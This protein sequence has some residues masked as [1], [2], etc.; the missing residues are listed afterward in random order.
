MNRT[1]LQRK[2]LALLILFLAM[3]VLNVASIQA[4]T[5]F[6][7]T[8][9][10]EIIA[11]P[12]RGLQKYSITNNTY[13]SASNYSSIS[14]STIRSWRTGPEKVT[15]IYRYFLLG[16]FM[17]TEIS[18]TYLNNIQ[19]DFDRIRNAGLKTL[20]R[21]SYTNRQSTD[22][23][24]PVKALILR[25]I[26]QLAP[27]LESNK[28]VIVAHQA[29]FIGTWGEWY[30]TNS[31]EFGTHGSISPTQW[32]NRK[33]VV[34][35]M[36]AGTPVEIPLQ[37]RYPQA[38]ITMYGSTPLTGETAY[39]DSPQAR[40][41]FYN[42]AFLNIWGDMGTYRN[43]GQFGNPVG[44]SDY[45]FLSNET[46]YLPMTGETNGL[47]AP[48]TDGDNS[49]MEMDLTNWSI[50][51]RDYHTSVINGWINSGHFDV[52]LRYLGYRFVLKT[53]TFEQ[54][55]A[56][57]DVTLAMENKGYA[58]PFLRREAWLIF[59]N[60]ITEEEKSF[61]VPGDIRTWEGEFDVVT[62][63]DI[64]QFEDGIYEVYLSIPDINL[65]D[66]PEYA[67]RL[68]NEDLWKP[69]SGRNLLGYIEIE[70]SALAVSIEDEIDLPQGALLR[71]NYPNPFNPGTVITFELAEGGPVR[72]SVFD[73][74]G[75]KVME[76]ENGVFP[77]GEHRVQWDASGTGS[78]VYII[79]LDAAGVTQ[80]IRSTLL[81]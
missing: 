74:A 19:I 80:T 15:V 36:L 71:Q 1:E 38:K 45:E 30:Y 79:R 81:K 77:A 18:E 47:N 67:I 34:D 49:V 46:Q 21:F 52:M 27:V 25:H 5:V 59:R 65:G 37:V 9:S 14:E 29:G 6:T 40:I 12:E 26:E 2:L 16:N 55:G 50:I 28:D 70:D 76:L 31:T 11:N 68:A 7:Y 69:E 48:R 73:I 63:V 62:P 10:D 61:L 20:V 4:Q 39:S 44:T 23:Q 60:L 32:Q 57:I 64:S 22:P 3:P 42:D 56:D 33:E 58:R 35:A 75:R 66:R 54:N 51:N 53:A 24:Q 78:G 41:G 72:L 8:E 43:T 17:E 13:Y